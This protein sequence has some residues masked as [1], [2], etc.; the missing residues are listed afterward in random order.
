MPKIMMVMAVVLRTGDFVWGLDAVRNGLV[1][2][3]VATAIAVLRTSPS[4]LLT[5]SMSLS[6]SPSVTPL[7]TGQA[8][9][10]KDAS[11]S[12]NG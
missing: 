4:Q 1:A 2:V 3:S 6:V 10:Q 9:D 5:R 11:G 7:R 12:R 8:R